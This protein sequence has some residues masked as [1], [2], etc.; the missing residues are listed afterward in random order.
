MADCGS[1]QWL[2]T[3]EAAQRIRLEPKTPQE[4]RVAGTGPKLYKLGP[5]RNACVVYR[6]SDL[7]VWI[8]GFGYRST[9]EHK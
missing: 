4:M 3:K 9:S 6:S 7:T 5:G 8:E 1:E 2:D